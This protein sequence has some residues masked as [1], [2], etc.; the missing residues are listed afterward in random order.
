MKR[1]ITICIVSFVLGTAPFASAKLVV[2]YTHVA[3]NIDARTADVSSDASRVWNFS[4]TTKLIDEVAGVGET[5]VTLYGGMTMT[6]SPSVTYNPYLRNNVANGFQ[7]TLGAPSQTGSSVKGVVVW[8]KADFINGADSET[9]AF[10]AGDS[11]SMNLTQVAGNP[12]D[13][14]F[15]IKQGGDYY[16]SNQKKTDTATGTYSLEPNAFQTWAPLSTADYSIGAF[17]AG[18]T[19]TDVEAVGFYVDYSKTVTGVTA[20]KFDD[21]QVN[22]ATG[23][24]PPPSSTFTNGVIVNYYGTTGNINARAA[25]STSTSSSVWN[26]SDT[27]VLLAR[28]G[29]TNQ[30]IYGGMDL[31]WSPTA[32]YTPN[33][34]YNLAI[35]QSQVN[36]GVGQDNSQ[37]GML[38]WNQADF[39]NTAAYT[40]VGFEA[41]DTM[42]FSLD[43]ASDDIDREIRFVAKQVDTYYVSSQTFGSVSNS[44]Y[45]LA[46]SSDHWAE[47][48]ADGN[49]TFDTNAFA[50]VSFTNIQAV[51][52]YI[53]YA[54]T[55]EQSHIRIDDFQVTARVPGS[56]PQEPVTEIS[57][58]TIEISGSD[59]VVG[60]QGTNNATYTVQ[61]REDLVA[62]GTNGW[63]NIEENIPG[64]NDFMS[65][66]T[67]TALPTAFYRTIAE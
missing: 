36:S 32:T 67:N 5:N 13:L 26:F 56:T 31:A 41:G 57:A 7:A 61:M 47:I 23:E 33:L 28:D 52:L 43:N 60:W 65:V 64:V 50:A 58:V 19:F 46:P 37:K 8:N 9:V 20:V 15:V 38:I 4:D 62:G 25:D 22:I 27:T 44:V 2:D 34:R 24:E 39:L 59:V 1:I 10:A 53:D 11:I 17:V 35:I 49:Y 55:N 48:S 14:R 16:I 54:R 12:R 30:V 42:S 45:S 29:G 6:W 66:T 40:N 63:I 3:G 21:F 18:T 51:G